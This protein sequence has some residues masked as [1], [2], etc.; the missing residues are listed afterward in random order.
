MEKHNLPD[1]RLSTGQTNTL[2]MQNYVMPS[3]GGFF[4]GKS[5]EAD[6]IWW[7]RLYRLSCRP[8]ICR[9]VGLCQQG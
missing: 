8:S 4:R 6:L 5:R 7:V 9:R 2:L 1:A 3:R